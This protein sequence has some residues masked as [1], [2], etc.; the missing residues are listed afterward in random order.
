MTWQIAKIASSVAAGWRIARITGATNGGVTG[1]GSWRIAK[2]TAGPPAGG[3]WKIA[4]ISAGA[5]PAGTGNHID[6]PLSLTTAPVVPI[7]IT[8][9]PAVGMSV[10]SWA[11]SI[12]GGAYASITYS[13]PVATLQPGGQRGDSTVTVTVAATLTTGGTVGP[14]SCV[15]TVRPA[16]A[17]RQTAAGLRP[18]SYAQ[19]QT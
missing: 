14:V 2:V 16:Y 9:T 13:G 1:S 17:F 5:A 15:V 8:A 4:T 12:S 6:L 11:W 7:T 10:A 3:T 18:L 19:V